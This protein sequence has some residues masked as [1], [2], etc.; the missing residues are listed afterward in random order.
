MSVRV[1][2]EFAANADA[3]TGGL[4]AEV[5][6]GPVASSVQPARAGAL[7][8]SM[9]GNM[10]R[11]LI[12]PPGSRANG[13]LPERSCDPGALRLSSMMHLQG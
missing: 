8:A 4:A 3:G 7:S 9:V 6:L 5:P 13:A 11:Y 1:S 10:E 2:Q 12:E